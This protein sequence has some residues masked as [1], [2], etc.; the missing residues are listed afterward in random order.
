MLPKFALVGD[1]KKL[2]KKNLKFIYTIFR[3]CL[4][5]LTLLMDGLLDALNLTSSVRE[6]AK[7]AHKLTLND[8]YKE[9]NR[10]VQT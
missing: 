3:T 1:Q 4:D 2:K 5:S 6:I 8:F 10:K 7:N 9:V